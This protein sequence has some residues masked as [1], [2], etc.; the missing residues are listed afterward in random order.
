[1]VTK[2]NNIT[3]IP[4]SFI[5]N[6]SLR[7]NEADYKLSI[8]RYISKLEA[9]SPIETDNRFGLTLIDFFYLVKNVLIVRQNTENIAENKRILFLEDQPPEDLNTEAITF[10]MKKR[11]PGLISRG[12]SQ[13]NG[14]R[15]ITPHVRSVSEDTENPGQRIIETGKYSDHIVYF[16]TYARSSMVALRRALWLENTL[17]SFNWFFRYFGFRVNHEETLEKED[18]MIGN[19]RLVRYP[20]SYFV[21]CDNLFYV[22]SQELREIVLKMNLQS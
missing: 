21:R 22:S 5:P 2:I 16:Y 13:T 12:S 4:D 17:D 1:M 19:L 9:T 8:D 20:V 15:E 18:E 7:L 3:E 10:E 11:L 6:T 14:V